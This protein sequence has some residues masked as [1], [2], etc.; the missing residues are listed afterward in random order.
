MMLKDPDSVWELRP[1]EK[2][3]GILGLSF[4]LRMGQ[5]IQTGNMALRLFGYKED[6]LDVS[7]FLNT[8][9]ILIN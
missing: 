8:A 4:M 3:N 2:R 1:Q 7:G 9:V 6:N 5:A